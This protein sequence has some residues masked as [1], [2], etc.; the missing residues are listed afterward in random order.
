[1]CVDYRALNSLTIKNKYTLPRIDDLLDQ[2]S[3]YH[4][5]RLQPDEIPCTAFIT[6]FGLYEFTVVPFGLTNSPSVFQSMMNKVLSPL[7]YKGVIVYPVS[8][9][10]LTLPTKA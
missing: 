4:Q 3:G 9:T 5:I 6:P 10:H 2:L 8:Y 7:L 1:M